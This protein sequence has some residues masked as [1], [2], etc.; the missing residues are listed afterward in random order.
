MAPGDPIQVGVYTMEQIVTHFV[1][2]NLWMSYK[3]NI[4]KQLAAFSGWDSTKFVDP[5]VLVHP[6][7]F[8]S[9]YLRTDTRKK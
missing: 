7:F 6:L 2:Q 1:Y 4:H 8:P 5:A 3:H 9:R